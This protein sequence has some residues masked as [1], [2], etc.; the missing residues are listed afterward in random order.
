MVSWTVDASV[1][2]DVPFAEKVF[3]SVPFFDFKNTKWPFIT[4][5]DML[6]GP[7]SVMTP[8]EFD[9]FFIDYQQSGFAQDDGKS[10]VSTATPA[11]TQSYFT[12]S[13]MEEQMV[14]ATPTF[15]LVEFGSSVY[16]SSI[17]NIRHVAKWLDIDFVVLVVNRRSSWKDKF[18]FWWSH[19]FPGV[20][21][22]LIDEEG[23]IVTQLGQC[24]FLGVGPKQGEGKT[25]KY[26]FGQTNGL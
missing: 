16:S 12:D 10:S 17:E 9:A 5:G 21:R 18:L 1:Y 13:N 24:A 25:S 2:V 22:D 3:D 6:I 26:L 8:S 11:Y 23:N 7:I 19:K 15:L 14:T 20:P 4:T